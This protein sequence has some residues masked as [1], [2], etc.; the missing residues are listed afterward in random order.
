[1]ERCSASVEATRELGLLPH[2]I[3]LPY[4]VLTFYVISRYALLDLKKKKRWT[5]VKY[6]E[7]RSVFQI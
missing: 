2:A 4:H 1:M 3:Y 7:T 5:Y 6:L